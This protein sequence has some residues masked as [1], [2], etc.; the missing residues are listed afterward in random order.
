MTPAKDAPE[1]EIAPPLRLRD[2][3]VGLLI[4]AAVAAVYR[5]LL[6]A[7]MIWDDDGHVTRPDLRPLHGLWRIW[8]EPGATQQ[9]YPL[10]HSAFW[11]EHRLWGDSALGYHAANA[12]LHALSAWLLYLL[13]R[14]LSVAG[15]AFGALAWALHPVCTE[16]VAW[17]SEQKNTLSAAFFLGAALAY[18]RFDRIRSKGAYA[19]ALLLFLA[20][21]A[22]KTVT[23]T[24][25]A[26]LLVLFWWKRGRLSWR[27]DAVPL[28]PFFAL[29][30]AAGAVTSWV[31]TAYIGAT[32]ES[33]AIGP[34]ERVQVAGRALWFYLGKLAWPS[35]LSFIYPKWDVSSASA[36]QY[37]YPAGA[38]AVLAALFALR[39][40]A[41]GPLAAALLFCGLLFPALGFFNVYPF[42]YSYV[43]DHF[44][45][46]ASA[47]VL[48]SVAA[49]L[50]RAAGRFGRAGL[51]A[52]G[53]AGALVLACLGALSFVQG[54]AYMDAETLWRTTLAHNPG[55][56]MAYQNLGGVYL[57]RG[58][59]LRAASNFRKALAIRPGDPEALN[60]LGVATMQQGRTDDA[61][62][63]YLQALESAPERAQTHL[64]LGVA[65]LQKREA[66]KA[67]DQFQ[68]AAQLEPRSAAARKDL[69]TVY[70]QEGNSDDAVRELEKA[71]QLEPDNAQT[72]YGLGSALVR[73]GRAAEALPIFRRSIDLDDSQGAVHESYAYVLQ[74]SDRREEALAEFARACELEPTRQEWHFALGNALAAAGR[75]DEADAQ[76]AKAPDLPEARER[77]ARSLTEKGRFAEAAG[78]MRAAAELAP[79]NP[80]IRNELG[81]VLARAGATEESLA[82]FS[83][84][85]ELRPGYAP[86]IANRGA[87]FFGLGRPEDAARDFEAAL[88]LPA[89][90][91]QGMDTSALRNNLGIALAR[92]GRSAEAVEQFRA[93]LAENPNNAEARRNLSLLTGSPASPGGR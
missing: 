80:E 38:A 75:G 2:L 74:G 85:I 48:A 88:A 8:T 59:A 70:L 13:L 42:L 31:E 49:V 14:R 61:I 60:E 26:A 18:L 15:A 21:L 67:A 29:G 90:A 45:Y 93:A 91:R 86:A 27:R 82:A 72:L 16:T 28:L 35:Q 25:P 20:A 3:G 4:L 81:S 76:F 1:A 33:F 79:E 37:A 10:L 12:G 7:G 43:A 17:I 40:R 47:A 6:A 9:Y 64:N 54:S 83:R 32:G 30:A 69:A 55:S 19:G 51:V 66:E 22:S 78:E 89:A 41:R 46:L 57:S 77:L 56:W 44:Q 65:L 24:L 23:A 52:G 58:D 53:S 68:H 63:L 87:A 92:A 5:P 36:A 71:A 50:A 62:A 34:A 39:G 73:A 84:A 11:A